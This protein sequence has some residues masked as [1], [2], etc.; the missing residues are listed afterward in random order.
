M[1]INAEDQSF[2]DKELYELYHIGF[3]NQNAYR[4]FYEGFYFEV[5]CHG[6][7]KWSY[8]VEKNNRMLF[9]SL[10]SDT[11]YDTAERAHTVMVLKITDY[12]HKRRTS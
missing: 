11:Y 4:R 8:H 6:K 7:K 3:Y 10:I 1:E 9:D 5:V 2:L 12:L